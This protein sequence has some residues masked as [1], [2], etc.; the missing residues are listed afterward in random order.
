MREQDRIP[1]MLQLLGALWEKYPDWRLAQLM[2]NAHSATQDSGNRISPRTRSWNAAYGNYSTGRR[3]AVVAF[4]F[5]AQH[6][7]ASHTRLIGFPLKYGRASSL[8]REPLTGRR[9][10]IAEP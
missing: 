2:L 5:H 9:D 7:S 8:E 10:R 3:K 1:K 6:S 4:R